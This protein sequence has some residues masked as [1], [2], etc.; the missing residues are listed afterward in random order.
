LLV[1]GAARSG[2]SYV[3]K[4]LTAAGIPACHECSGRE[5]TFYDYEVSWL[6]AAYL[7]DYDGYVVQ[8]VRN[9]LDVIASL[10]SNDTMDP[11]RPYIQWLHNRMPRL[12]TLNP[13]EAACLYWVRWNRKVELYADEWWR[14]EDLDAD[15]ITALGRTLLF[16][17]SL[18]AAEALESTPHNVNT[19]GSVVEL[20]WDELVFGVHDLAERYGYAP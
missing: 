6:G 15:T 17:D 14:V 19:R 12:R 4:V 1:T 3:A 18:R 9:P 2:T 16:P 5:A 8:L 13:L 10:M 20:E 11:Q 7:H